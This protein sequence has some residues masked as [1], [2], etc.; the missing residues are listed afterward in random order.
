MSKFI[1]NE[2][3]AEYVK[4]E[5]SITHSHALSYLASLATA[6]IL[7]ELITG[8][9]LDEA[10]SASLLHRIS[11]PLILSNSSKRILPKTS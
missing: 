6:I 8:A 7:R 2:K 10:I 5:S 9:S 1:P 11:L 3:L 4:K